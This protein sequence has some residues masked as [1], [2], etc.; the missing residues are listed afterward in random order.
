MAGAGFDAEIFRFTDPAL[1]RR[2]GWFAYLP[3]AVAALR[4]EPSQVGVTVDGEYDY[5]LS[6]LVLVANG[7][8]AIAPA[9]KIYPGITVDDGWLDVLIFTA[10]KPTQIAATLGLVGRQ[11]LD[12]SPH[13]IRRRGRAVRIEATPPLT[14]E[15]DGDVVGITPRDFHVVPGGMTVITPM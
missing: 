2:L 9:F 1:K 4:I 8:S 10:A 15:L 11:R 5:A 3:A 12:R 14:V 6:P 13:V 7:G